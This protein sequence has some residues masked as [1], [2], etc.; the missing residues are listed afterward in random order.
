MID[1]ELQIYKRLWSLWKHFMKAGGEN[2]LLW[3][4]LQLLKTSS[5]Q[6]LLLCLVLLLVTNS[7][8]LLSFTLLHLILTALSLPLLLYL[9]IHCLLFI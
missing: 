9:F 3:V 8:F 1:Q 2:S 6:I 5:V 7:L 4:Y